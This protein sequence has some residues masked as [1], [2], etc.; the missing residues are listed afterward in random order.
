MA[1][2]TLK[3]SETKYRD[4]LS[5]LNDKISVL[6]GYLGDLQGK[7]TQIERAYKGP[8]ADDAINTIKKNEKVVKD[9]I[10]KVTTQRDQIQKYL[11]SMDKAATEIQ[12][13]YKTAADLADHVFD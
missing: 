10:D 5:K 9:A 3:V 12:T 13:G 4:T 1:L 7:R 8:Q 2:L 11:D 6:E